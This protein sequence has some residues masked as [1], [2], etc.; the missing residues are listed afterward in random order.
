MVSVDTW[1]KKNSL[2]YA[3][4]LYMKNLTLSENFPENI[5]ALRFLPQSFF[6]TILI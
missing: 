2:L 3:P 6:I 4:S 5:P 1:W